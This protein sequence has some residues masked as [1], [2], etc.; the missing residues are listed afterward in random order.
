MSYPPQEELYTW[1]KNLKENV[2]VSKGSRLELETGTGK[3]LY[4][5]RQQRAL[6]DG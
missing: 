5:P 6:I 4:H 2:G 3:P 1:Y